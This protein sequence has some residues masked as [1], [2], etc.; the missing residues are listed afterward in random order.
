[1]ARYPMKITRSAA[2]A[3]LPLFLACISRLAAQN[4]Q[5][6]AAPAPLPTISV[7][8]VTTEDS[9]AYASWVARSNQHL[10]KAGG[11]ENFTH[12]Y[13]G[14]IAG[15]DTGVV[16]AVREADS[17]AAISKAVETLTKLPE[18]AEIQ[19]HLERIRKIG[20]ASLMKAVYAE[21]GYPQEW[22]FIVQVNVKDQAKYVDLI[23]QMRGLYDQHGLKDVKINL[24][25]VI[26]G[27]DQ[28]THD[29]V[30][31]AP[32]ADRLM[33]CMD[34]TGAGWLDDWLKSADDVRTVVGNGIY[35]EISE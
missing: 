4:D 35:R 13:E 32:N 5:A 20:P 17:A 7:Q 33:E 18:H 3:L 11:P 1:M 34:A 22:L 9:A 25:R 28:F 26:A 12:V 29:V 8:A 23:K 2:A 24:F 14:V 15:K 10:Q 31:S 16:F 19:R 30:F 27:R 6:P 21:G